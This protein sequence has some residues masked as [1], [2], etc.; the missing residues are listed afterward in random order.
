VTTV[1]TIT[2]QGIAEQLEAFIRK[3]GE[4]ADDDPGFG[5]DVHVFE[6]GYLDSLGVVRVID[7]LESSFGI[8]FTDEELF[9]QRFTTIDG[10]SDIVSARLR[11]H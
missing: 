10:I 4:V 5:R 3:A 8:E 6:A 1:A 9:D 2:R 11:D 7:H